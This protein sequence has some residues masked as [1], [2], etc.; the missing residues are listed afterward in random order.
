MKLSK[1]QRMQLFLQRNYIT[2]S[3]LAKQCD[4]SETEIFSF[5]NAY[6]DLCY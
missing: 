4:V 5:S 3:E 6:I 1:P 2:L